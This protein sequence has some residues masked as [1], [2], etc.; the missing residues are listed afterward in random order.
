[1]VHPSS[2][3]PVS[4]FSHFRHLHQNRIHAAAMVAILK[5]LV[6]IC[7]QTVSRMERKLGE[8]HPGSMEI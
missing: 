4:N 3:S 5:V 7:S 2:V 8:R 1:M 6:V